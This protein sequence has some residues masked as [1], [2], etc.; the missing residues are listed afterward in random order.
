MPDSMMSTTRKENYLS[1]LVKSPDRRRSQRHGCHFLARAYFTSHGA[2]G[3]KEVEVAALDISQHGI[4]LSSAHAEDVPLHFYLYIGHYQHSI[5]CA[6]VARQ[7]Q[8][9]RCEFLRRETME[10]IEFLTSVSDPKMTLSEIRH[11]LFGYMGDN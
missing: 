6:V 8:I 10:M 9:L 7:D 5:S 3:I 4:C 2:R 1:R 11:P